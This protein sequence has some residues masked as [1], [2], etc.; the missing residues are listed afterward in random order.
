MNKI[1]SRRKFLKKSGLAI[2]TIAICACSAQQNSIAAAPK[3]KPN[4]ILFLT[5]DQ[6]WT[7]T[8]VQ[9]MKDRPDSKSDF[10]QTPALERLAKD[11]MIF[12]SAYSPAPTCTPTRTSLQFGKSPAR[13]RQTVVHDVLAKQNGWDCKDEI[14]IG[15]MI[16]K[17]DPSYATA[18]LGKWGIDVLRTPE[19][20]GYDVT[21]GNTNNG[22]GDWLVHM[23]K[24]LPDDDPKRIF[25]VTKR[26]NDFMEA[27]AKA[28]NPFFMQISH[29]AVHV[30][31]FARKKTIEK[32]LKLPRGQKCI[33]SDYKQP[34][35]NRNSWMMNY[36]AMIEDL[37]T[38]LAMV[39]DKV[40]SLGIKDNTYIIFISDNGGGFRDNKPLKGGKA[41]LWEGGLRVPMVV[42]GPDVPKN[43]YCDEPVVGWDLYPTFSELAGNNKSLPKEYDGGS[44]CDLFKKGNDGKV[45]RGT[46]ELIFHFPWYAG[47]LPMSTIR[48]GDYKLAMNLL[49]KEYRL[50]N[51]AKDIG[52]ENDISGKYPTIAK[53]LHSKLENY[54]KE[55]Q[56]EDLQEMY[57]ARIKELHG[58]M[59]KDANDPEALKRHQNGL[60]QVKRSQSQKW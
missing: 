12:S 54:L 19:K 27:Q 3:A 45:K 44:L 38:G 49:N 8:S 37:D 7:D 53:K 50:Y 25:S 6:G 26:A 51:L 39:L 32:Y 23:K 57:A 28:Q 30:S 10:Y 1:I 47:T 36:A 20:A 59:E 5:D 17:I 33:D 18:H 58:Y 4:I 43:T 16:K 34:Y 40:Q 35:P 14:T 21:D 2:S 9:M 41:N 29:Y 11:G 42:A 24:P 48:D 60:D 31:N 46:Q 56:A 52:E 13:L 15:Q 22:E 55:V